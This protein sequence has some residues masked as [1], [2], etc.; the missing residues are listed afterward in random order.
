[1]EGSFEEGRDEPMVIKQLH[2]AAHMQVVKVCKGIQSFLG[3]FFFRTTILRIHNYLHWTP[4]LYFSNLQQP[5]F[6]SAILRC[7]GFWNGNIERYHD[8]SL[9]VR[10]VQHASLAKDGFDKVMNN[11]N[12]DVVDLN[13]RHGVLMTCSVWLFGS[14][15]FQLVEQRQIIY[16]FELW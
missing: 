6:S 7:L 1:M 8:R 11:T 3:W 16:L 10:V 4:T 12:V 15:W 5:Q 9:K 14:K 13:H 2:W